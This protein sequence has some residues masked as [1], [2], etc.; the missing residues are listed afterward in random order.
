M[1]ASVGKFVR[2]FAADAGITEVAKNVLWIGV[3]DWDL[4]EFHSMHLP[5]GTSYNSYL[6]Q[7]DKPT[8]IDAVK[9]PLANQWIGRLQSIAGEDLKSIKQIVINH[10]E[11]DH[12]SALPI[13]AQRFPHIEIL[14]TQ[15]CLKGLSRFFD[16]RKWNTHVIKYN[17]PFDIGNGRKAVMAHIPMA[18]WP[19]SGATYLPDQKILF[20]NDAFGQHIASTKRFYDQIDPCLW[21]Q[22]A[23]SYY[24]N[25]LQPLRRPVLNAIKTASSLPAID[26]ILPSHGVGYRRHEDITKAISL[27]Q[28]WAGQKVEPKVVILYDCTWFG[29]EK[30]AVSIAS[31]AAKVP[32]VD[33]KM[34]HARRTHITNTATECLDAASVA[35][36]S[37]TLH[38]CDLPDLAAHLSYL[39][40]LKIAK[41]SGAIFGTYGWNKNGVPKDI[42]QQLFTPLKIPEIHEPVMANW[43]PDLK[44]LKKCEELGKV[45]AEDA[46]KK[47]KPGC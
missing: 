6:I 10:A 30:M 7:T 33:V 2:K 42:R 43:S 39:R 17:E 5:V 38:E 41:K 14:T 26:M 8:I 44:D 1:L 15:I 24:A 46:L 28:K 29:T 45:L 19:E 31:G 23:K 36:G 37:S 9:E 21:S 22:E 20:P 12:T 32:G 34:I 35:I 18:H 4:R 27:Y 25:I 47:S 16:T 13:L 40:C 11:P 3:N